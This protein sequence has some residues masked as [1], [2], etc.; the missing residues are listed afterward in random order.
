MKNHI[1]AIII[2]T[3]TVGIILTTIFLCVKTEQK[4]KEK[5]ENFYNNPVTYQI[6]SVIIDSRGEVTTVWI[7]N[8]NSL[9]QYCKYSLIPSSV[10]GI[11]NNGNMYYYHKELWF[12]DAKEYQYCVVKAFSPTQRIPVFE[13]HLF[14]GNLPSVNTSSHGKFGEY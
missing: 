10:Y 12:E 5:W 11:I 4:A 14:P 1:S 7:K 9:Q 3:A 8:G 6:K 13:F 2:L